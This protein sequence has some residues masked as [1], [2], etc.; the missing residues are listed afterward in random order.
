MCKNNKYF[1]FY[2]NQQGVSVK[3]MPET[4]I[5]SGQFIMLMLN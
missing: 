4:D 3:K 5:G 1:S 2:Q